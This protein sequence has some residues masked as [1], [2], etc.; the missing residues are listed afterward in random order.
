MMAKELAS[1]SWSGGGR[2][3]EVAVGFA[4]A[5]LEPFESRVMSELKGLA[6]SECWQGAPMIAE[7]SIHT[8][9]SALGSGIWGM[10][11]SAMRTL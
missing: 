2:A 7:A 5:K 9:C 3:S 10:G 11:K 4:A 6:C 8:T 1:L